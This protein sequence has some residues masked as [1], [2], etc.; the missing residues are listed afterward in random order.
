MVREL[1]EGASA[2][3]RR[4]D[5][6]LLAG[7][8]AAGNLGFSAV[9]TLLPLWA[10]S[11]GRLGL[12]PLVFGLV[13]ATPAIGGL[14]AGTFA[15]RALQRFGPGMIQRV[16][17]P[18][19]G[20]CFLLVAVP[21][22]AATAVAMTAYGAFSVQLNVM[23]VSHR[24]STVSRE[25]FGRVNAVYRWVVLG[26]TPVG[27]LVAGLLAVSLGTAAAF[28]FAGL[29]ATAAG[30]AAPFLPGADQLSGRPMNSQQ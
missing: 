25:L 6:I 10:V 17:A 12:S 5:L 26:V 24:Q 19:I 29:V 7:V 1:R 3:S 21:H 23:S 13:M 27:S 14:A 15:A 30:L 4:S 22:V 28:L 2:F 8:A 11:P 9:S 20:A 18:A 16:C